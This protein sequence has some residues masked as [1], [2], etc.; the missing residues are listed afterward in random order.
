MEIPAGWLASGKA[1]RNSRNLAKTVFAKGM[2]AEH[3][4]GLISEG[5]F[6]EM[7]GLERRRSQRSHKPFLLMLI[8]IDPLVEDLN[9]QTPRVLRRII[10]ALSQCTR[11]TD[12]SGWYATGRTLG[13]IFTE[14]GGVEPS[15]LVGVLRSKVLQALAR[16][17]SS[18]QVELMRVSFHLFPE[19]VKPE[20][21]NRPADDRL[22]PDISDARG[23]RK[24]AL[25]M[26]RVMDVAGSAVAL[27]LLAPVFLSVA[28]AIKLT[29]RGPVLFKQRRLAKGG[30]VFQCL[31]F[32]TM[33]TDNDPKIHEEYV[34]NFI[35]GT[36]CGESPT[37]LGIY[38][39]QN[40]PRV[41]AVGRFLR[42]TSMDE[43]PQLF[44]VLVGTMSLVGPRPPI[45][46]E[47]SSYDLWHK[48]RVL[49]VTPGIT[50][51]WQV[52]GRSR[53]TFDEMVRLDLRYMQQW[54]LWLDCK[55]LA[56]TP[57]AVFSGDGAC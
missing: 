16:G 49:E 17:L 19:E 18:D 15:S 28:L 51:L 35:A 50:G 13:V 42:R 10:S 5:T 39:I 46:Y 12:I 33:R 26:K 53:T 20:D 9:G 11:E 2:R 44:N 38:K 27:I 29:S 48:R 14:L 32:R 45:P 57:L 23:T 25:G 30:R 21:P 41:T 24:L 6:R 36:V 4:S 34:R 47:L 52:T 8:G 37:E 3:T 54:S 7:L 1:R 56:L 31:K 22:Y 40:D 55:I 43:L